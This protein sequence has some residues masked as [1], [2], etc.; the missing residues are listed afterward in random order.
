MKTVWW[1]AV[2]VHWSICK[3]LSLNV[4]TVQPYCVAK[5]MLSQETEVGA[6][7]NLPMQSRSS[8][9]RTCTSQMSPPA[10]GR[11]RCVTDGRS[12]DNQTLRLPTRAGDDGHDHQ[13]NRID[14]VADKSWRRRP[15]SSTEPNRQCS[16]QELETTATLIDRTELT[17]QQTRAGDDGHAH[18]QNRVDRVADKSWRRW[19]HLS[20][21]PN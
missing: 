14:S 9:H 7:S 8:N 20:T 10:G 16:R 15:R 4:T 13:Q 11:I 5:G 21:E 6:L 2:G 17:V 3:L 12:L 18:Q 1:R 19:P